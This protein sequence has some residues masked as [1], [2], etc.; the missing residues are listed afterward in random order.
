MFGGGG[1]GKKHGSRLNLETRSAFH[2]TCYRFLTSLHNDLNFRCRVSDDTSVVCLGNFATYLLRGAQRKASR[3]GRDKARGAQAATRLPILR[4]TFNSYENHHSLKPEA[5]AN[6]ALGHTCAKQ[7]RS[8]RSY[9][10]AKS[11]HVLDLVQ[12]EGAACTTCAFS[13]HR[14]AMRRSASYLPVP[15]LLRSWVG[16]RL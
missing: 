12:I 5:K 15:A 14:I 8:R 9:F 13:D 6:F 11:M 2:A 16:V 1:G 10:G 4:R 7:G 3:A